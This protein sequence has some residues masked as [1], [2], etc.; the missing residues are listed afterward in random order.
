[1]D[2]IIS[3]LPFIQEVAKDFNYAEKIEGDDVQKSCVKDCGNNATHIVH[4]VW[5]DCSYCD[6]HLPLSYVAKRAAVEDV[7]VAEEGKNK[8]KNKKKR[9][10][11]KWKSELAWDMKHQPVKR[12]L[13]AD[14]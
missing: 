3:F 13:F 6:Q 11:P 7:V 2:A 8:N 14:E 5:G 1:M 4:T 9:S 10:V 12:R